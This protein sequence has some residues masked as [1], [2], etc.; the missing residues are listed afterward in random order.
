MHCKEYNVKGQNQNVDIAR[1]QWKIWNNVLDN[2]EDETHDGQ[3]SSIGDDSNNKDLIGHGTDNQE[4][5]ICY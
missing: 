3:S 5:H 1:W 4:L 2:F